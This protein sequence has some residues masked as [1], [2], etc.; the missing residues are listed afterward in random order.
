M[1]WD[2]TLSMR[3]T[4]MIYRIE[5]EKIYIVSRRLPSIFSPNKHQGTI[6]NAINSLIHHATLIAEMIQR[7]F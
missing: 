6:M 5:W 4:I 3:F 2:A 1:W 7:L